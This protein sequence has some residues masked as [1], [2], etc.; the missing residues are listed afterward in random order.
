MCPYTRTVLAKLTAEA[1]ISVEQGD[2]DALVTMCRDLLPWIGVEQV[3]HA[4]GKVL[5][6]LLRHGHPGMISKIEEDAFGADRL[7][8]GWNPENASAAYLDWKYRQVFGIGGDPDLA[9]AKA[10]LVAAEALWSHVDE[11]TRWA[12][13][14]YVKLATAHGALGN[15]QALRDLGENLLAGPLTHER[16]QGGLLR[17]IKQLQRLCA[18][19]EIEILFEQ[20]LERREH[21]SALVEAALTAIASLQAVA[22][23]L[24][25]YERLGR[26]LSRAVEWL[27]PHGR[28]L[29]DGRLI[30]A[31]LRCGEFHQLHRLVPQLLARA[32]EIDV[33]A[34][35]LLVLE[36]L[37][38]YDVLGEAGRHIERVYELDSGDPKAAMLF[39]RYL[40]EQNASNAKIESVFE[41]L[42]VDAPHYNDAVLWRAQRHYRLVEHTKLLSWLASHPLHDPGKAE[43]LLN[44]VYAA[45]ERLPFPET[46]NPADSDRL[47]LDALGF[48]APVLAPLLP[49]INGDL[50]PAAEPPLKELRNTLLNVQLVVLKA[51]QSSPN[52]PLSD[53][54]DIGRELFRVVSKFNYVAAEGFRRRNLDLTPWG[55]VQHDRVRAIY[56]MLHQVIMQLSKRVI[57]AGLEDHPISDVRQLCQAAAMHLRSAIAVG[58]EENS[59]VLL[60]AMHARGVAVP[61]VL[62]LLERSALQQGDLRTAEQFVAGQVR[63]E[64]QFYGIELFHTWAQKEAYQSKVLVEQAPCEGTFKYID[65]HGTFH[66]APHEVPGT[67]VELV[68]APGLRIRDIELLVGSRGTIARPHSIHGRDHNGYPRVSSVRFNYG[69]GGCRLGAA[70]D[71][72]HVEE[73]VIVLGNMDAPYWRNYYH[74]MLLILTRVAVLLDRGLFENRRLL[75]PI[76]LSEWMMTSLELSGLPQERMFRYS[77]E[78]EVLVDDAWVVGSVEYAAAAL[79]E[80]LQRRLWLAANVDPQAIGERAIWLSRREEPQRYLA[81]MVNPGTLGLL[82]QVRLCAGAKIIAGPEGSSFTNLLFARPGT[83]V[84]TLMVAGGGGDYETWLDMCVMGG[85][86][87]QWVFGR[88]DPRKAWWGFHYEPYEVDFAVVERELHRLMSETR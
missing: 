28:P 33:R 69:R 80:P 34:I 11:P 23:R 5:R 13:G 46:V 60:H 10:L 62:Q 36:Q 44:R 39:G 31:L 26:L 41:R 59:N 40:A 72:L 43:P 49:V 24:S 21:N 6:L 87:Q 52:V 76:E 79:M 48:L 47:G 45:S 12:Y 78:Q 54:L 27:E 19:S 58:A 18:A 66:T 55:G 64:G 50:S 85:L 14:L 74:W 77:G 32:D 1:K 8:S 42:R 38:R 16:Q 51:T 71:R 2:P 63:T 29:A 30:K 81:N 20:V 9:Q 53:Y 73:P 82:D 70:N 88:Q 57:E 17:V 84:L 7:L 4:L 3:D 25:D 35:L 68:H 75:V 61:I 22:Q 86:P 56:E 83:R 15:V 65:R 37:Q 67:R